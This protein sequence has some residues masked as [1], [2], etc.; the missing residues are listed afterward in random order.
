MPC[1]DG[2][3]CRAP[4]PWR[5]GAHVL[6]LGRTVELVCD[7]RAGVEQ[8]TAIGCLQD[9]NVRAEWVDATKASHVRLSGTAIRTLQIVDD[10]TWLL[11]MHRRRLQL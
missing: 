10:A 7:S 11:P 3:L 1:A 4:V 9:R 2:N 8:R 6:L 5:L